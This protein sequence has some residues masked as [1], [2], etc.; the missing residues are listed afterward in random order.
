M[1]QAVTNE[2]TDDEIDPQMLKVV[3]DTICTG[4]TQ[5]L[6]Q[7]FRSHCENPSKITPRTA[8]ALL[9][10]K[11]KLSKDPAYN[12]LRIETI[13]ALLRRAPRD[14]VKNAWGPL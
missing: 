4:V 8:W 6:K 3:I 9:R 2:R 10:L 5:G 11:D 13:D 14:A 12:K 7:R 1:D